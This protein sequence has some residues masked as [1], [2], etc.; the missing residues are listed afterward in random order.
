MK[1]LIF[2]LA[3]MASFVAVEAQNLAVFTDNT[4]EFDGFRDKSYVN[5]T[6]PSTFATFEGRADKIPTSTDFKKEGEESLKFAWNAKDGGDWIAGVMMSDWSSYNLEAYKELNFWVYSETAVAANVLPV[7]MLENNAGNVKTTPVSLAEFLPEGIKAGEWIEVKVDKDK[8]LATTDASYDVTCVKAIFFKQ[9]AT[10]G[11]DHTIYIDEMYWIEDEGYVYVPDP[12]F[13]DSPS[14]EY[15]DTS[16]LNVTEPSSLNRVNGDKFA[17]STSVKYEGENS[18]ELTWNSAE[19]GNWEALVAGLGWGKFDL[20]EQNF[21][22]MWVYS[23]K[24]IAKAAMPKVQFEGH[25]GG[26]TATVNLADYMKSDLVAGEWTEIKVSID[27]IKSASAEFTAFN[28]IKGLFFVQNVADNLEH[29]MYID[30]ITFS[31]DKPS[32]VESVEVATDMYYTEGSVYGVEG[33]VVVY[34][35]TGVVVEKVYAKGGKAEISL[36]RGVYIIINNGRTSKVAI[37]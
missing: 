36:E 22:S 25:V 11:A 5:V 9:N 12:L 23:D 2:T 7:L 14:T 4:D 6:A 27:D 8:L 34:D 3:A 18:L 13:M 28:N 29:T 16:W 26:R 17:V 21:V 20:S 24:G 32:S 37:Q 10:D 15:Y 31:K 19:G 30:N 33:E 35:M 1:K